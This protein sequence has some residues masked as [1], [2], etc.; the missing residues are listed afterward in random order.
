MHLGFP[1]NLG[2]QVTQEFLQPDFLPRD[3]ELPR[4][5]VLEKAVFLKFAS[6]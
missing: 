2:F 5:W 1:V 6:N 4:I 3:K